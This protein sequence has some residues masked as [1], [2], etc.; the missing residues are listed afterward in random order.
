M[1]LRK[2]EF[3]KT[4]HPQFGEITAPLII[5]ASRATD[6]PAFYSD[7]LINRFEQGYAAKINPYDRSKISYIS[8]KKVKAI[9]FWSKIPEPL[10][11]RLDYFNTRKIAYYFQ[12][13]LNDYEKENLE[14]GLPKLNKRIETFQR[15]SEKIGK[16]KVI[17][18][19]DPLVKTD[20]TSYDD[21]LERITKIADKIVPFTD[22]LVF[23]FA[24]IESYR[25]VKRAFSSRKDIF[26]L[27]PEKYQATHDE[28]ISFVKKLSAIIPEL[29]KLNPDFQIAS[30]A[31][32][33]DYSIYGILPNRCIDDELLL[34][35]SDDAELHQF[36]HPSIFRDEYYLKDRGQRKNC[37][38]ILSRDIGAYDSCPHFCLYCYANSSKEAVFNKIK[39]FNKMSD[40][41]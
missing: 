15:L 9:V 11:D 25:K 1:N 29:K 32:S 5:S 31:D 33:I 6:I 12:F 4:I 41:L 36:L 39:S 19:F 28:K 16:E 34:K 13:T 35:I 17:W 22:K 27:T 24:E 14:P 23:S 10:I 21:L 3:P 20:I 7:W 38:C 30:C 40:F 26:S 37:G 2:A 18:R 8:L